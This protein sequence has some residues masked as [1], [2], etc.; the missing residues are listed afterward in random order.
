[1]HNGDVFANTTNNSGD[2]T[3]YSYWDIDRTK[4]KF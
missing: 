1:M 2:A 4:L 3:M